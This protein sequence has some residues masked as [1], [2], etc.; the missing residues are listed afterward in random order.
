MFKIL[1]VLKG[2]SGVG[3]LEVTETIPDVDEITAGFKLLAQ[4]VIA[5]VTLWSL[6]K[7]K[8]PQT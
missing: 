7:K 4:I 1:N 2:G 6:F 8:K 3:L 5:I